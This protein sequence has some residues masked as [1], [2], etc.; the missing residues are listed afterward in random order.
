MKGTI[1]KLK[2]GYGFIAG[3][4]GQDFFFHWTDL[5]KTSKQFRNLTEGETCDFEPSV[6]DRG[7]RATIVKVGE[8]EEVIHEE[9][10]I[11]IADATVADSIDYSTA[12]PDGSSK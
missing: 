12:T 4:S 7:P 2:S 9:S 11:A 10:T 5:T 1:R 3:D 8:L 6:N